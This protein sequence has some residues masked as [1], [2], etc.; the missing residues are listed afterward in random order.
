[1]IFLKSFSSSFFV[2]HVIYYV[3]SSSFLLLCNSGIGKLS[4]IKTLTT[5]YFRNVSN[6]DII[7]YD[8]GMLPVK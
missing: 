2:M 5:T 3:V 1:M 8:V 6:K 7:T 4:N